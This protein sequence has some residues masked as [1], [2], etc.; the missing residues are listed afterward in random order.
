MEHI[1]AADIGA[2]YGYTLDGEGV[3]LIENETFSADL[4]TVTIRGRNIH[5]GLA[6]G[7]MVNAVRAMSE[8]VA[9]L[10]RDRLSPETTDQRSGFI[11]PYHLGGGVGQAAVKLILRDFETARLAEHAELLRT[12]AR[13]IEGVFAGVKIDVEVTRQYRNMG[14]GLSREPRAVEYAEQAHRRLGRMA[15]RTIVRGGT[16]GAMLTERGL[17]TPNLST[18]QH[19]PHSRLEWAC[20]DEMVQAAEVLVELVQVWAEPT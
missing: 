9:R 15:K 19:N 16:D 14:E 3:D 2:D 11:H 13:Q 4:A 8:F 6:K 17:P 12:L 20:L 5:P 18:G 1:T 10:P 7:R